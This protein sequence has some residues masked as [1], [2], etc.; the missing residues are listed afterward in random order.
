MKKQT[1]GFTLY[2]IMVYLT[3]A[4]L[5][6]AVASSSPLGEIGVHICGVTGLQ[7][8]SHR[9]T[10]SPNRRY[11]RSLA[12]LDVGDP[13]TVRTI[14]FL[15][16]DRPY[17][18]DVVQRMKDEILSIQAFF[19][20]QM[21]VHGYGKLTFRVETDPQGEPIVHRV[22]GEH[23]DSYYIDNPDPMLDQIE[24]AFNLDVNIY[25]IV[26]D[27]SV[28]RVSRGATGFAGR[29]FTGEFSDP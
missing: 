16:N 26:I 29:G 22:D 6:P 1:L 3:C 12:N 10:Q 8:D 20:E 9:S 24:R 25:L 27:N 13:R 18:A 7:S 23:P 2:L 21:G 11:A 15:P 14:Y 28:E 5:N 17:R 4:T 19:A